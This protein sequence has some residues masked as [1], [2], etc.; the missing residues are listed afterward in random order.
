MSKKHLNYFD[1]TKAEI[2]P[3]E[4]FDPDEFR[5]WMQTIVKRSIGTREYI[6]VGNYEIP[7]QTSPLVPPGEIWVISGR[8]IVTKYKNVGIPE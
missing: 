5:E 1:P 8:Q 2:K 3:I 7:V 4:T 6:R